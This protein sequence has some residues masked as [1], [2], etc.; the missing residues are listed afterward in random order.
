MAGYS[1]SFSYLYRRNNRFGRLHSDRAEHDVLRAPY[2][3]RM[4]MKRADAIR[5]F[6]ASPGP[7]LSS[8]YKTEFYVRFYAV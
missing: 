7:L 3:L 6:G 5:L 1:G 2:F 8:P 4:T